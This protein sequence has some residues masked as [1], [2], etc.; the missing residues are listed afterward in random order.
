MM[1][2]MQMNGMHMSVMLAEDV[3]TPELRNP[4]SGGMH[5]GN[6]LK[7]LMRR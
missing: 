5:L 2:Y 4:L 1:N 6:W 7:R 3:N